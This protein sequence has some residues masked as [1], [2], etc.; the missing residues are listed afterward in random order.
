M[1][2]RL[3]I[4]A[5]RRM[6]VTLSMTL[7]MTLA[8][9]ALGACAASAAENCMIGDAALCAANPNCHWDFQR[10]G[11]EQGPPPH[12]DACAAHG[13]KDICNADTTIGCKW[14]AEKASCESAK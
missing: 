7:S 12:E 2:K 8:A 5:M 9:M 13:G 4:R 6:I 14:N 10:R 1:Q 11:C 3:P